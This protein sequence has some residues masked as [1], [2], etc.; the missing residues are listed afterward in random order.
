MVMVVVV[1]I[2]VVVMVMLVVVVTALEVL[3]VHSKTPF[4]NTLE[5]F[6]IYIIKKSGLIFNEQLFDSCNPMS[7]VL[8]V[9]F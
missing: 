8:K 1:V 7:V 3:E 4:L 5:K 6:K 9:F 2:I